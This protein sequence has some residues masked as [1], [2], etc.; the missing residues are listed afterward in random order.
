ME[1]FDKAPLEAEAIQRFQK[2]SLVELNQ[3]LVEINEFIPGTRT[4]AV[5]SLEIEKRALEF[6]LERRREKMA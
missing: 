3:R 1:K 5:E 6:E 2:M 4:D